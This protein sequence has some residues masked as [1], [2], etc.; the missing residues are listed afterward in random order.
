MLA[1]VMRNDH[2]IELR[3]ALAGG[4]LLR[5]PVVV[6]DVE[7]TGIVT[8]RDRVYEIGMV[9]LDPDGQVVERFETLVRPD[10]TLASRLDEALR[11]APTFGEVAGEVVK[12]LRRGVVAGH[13][14]AFD[15]TMLNGELVRIGAGLPEVPY[16]CTNDLALALN[17]GSPT[18]RFAMLCHVLGV[19]MPSWH[20]AAGDA[21]ATGRLL[22]RLLAIAD[23]RG[24]GDRLRT[25]ARF[26]GPAITWP[27]LPIG[28]RLLPRDPATF[29]PVG[30]Q[31]DSVDPLGIERGVSVKVEVQLPDEL[32]FKLQLAIAKLEVRAGGPVDTA[33]LDA[34]WE[35]WDRGNFRGDAGLK[36]LQGILKVFM[37]DG[38][39]AAPEVA[40]RIAQ[41]LRYDPALSD[42]ETSE[43]FTA[44]LAVA[45]V[46]NTDDEEQRRWAIRDVV[47][48]WSDF[49]ASRQDI[50]GLA[51]LV[52]T[53]SFD[54]TLV[55]LLGVRG[56]V[57]RMRT[58]GQ[59]PA[60][61]G[62]AKKLSAAL[63]GAGATAEAADVCA[64]WAQG[65]A[66]S[67]SSAEGLTV[68]DQARTAGWFSRDL[69]NRHS[70][71][72]ERAKDW[73]AALRVSEE[74]LA[75]APGDEQLTKRR[76][77]CLKRL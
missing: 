3:P 39:E 24:L 22:L 41:F 11:E 74:G 27:S 49:L 53:V 77:R 54:P 36:R 52:T 42:T 47:E 38:D 9:I 65:L 28:G 48:D 31:P 46:A 71:L 15:L 43:A 60:A 12:R 13:G 5:D 37:A 16:L 40:L 10:G 73:S 23:Q 56:L 58:A 44:A 20:T 21:D 55:S 70:L 29:P 1:R 69:L 19:D 72:L 32:A 2:N 66:E 17:V 68:C 25:P 64:E 57:H 50:D 67:G 62:A 76:E 14:S 51:D 8:A 45:K 30:D 59:V 75:L 35:Q 33:E 6:L 61:V 26:D 63:A 18:R 34:A 4:G 7:T